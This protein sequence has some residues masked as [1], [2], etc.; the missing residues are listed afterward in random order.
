MPNGDLASDFNGW[1]EY[2]TIPSAASMSIPTTGNLTVEGWMRPDVLE[3]PNSN[4][5]YVAWMGKCEGY[6]PTCE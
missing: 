1:S 5:G 4:S 2:L 3:Y 6:A